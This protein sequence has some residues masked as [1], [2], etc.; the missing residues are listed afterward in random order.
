MRA[1]AL[2]LW[3]RR[4]CSPPMSIAAPMTRRMFPR[5]EPMIDALTT[6]WRPGMQGEERD[7]ELRRVAERDVQEAADARVRR[8]VRAPRSH[9][10]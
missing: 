9:G 6:S 7:D 10:P 2:K 8:G 5:I 1:V 4:T 3:R